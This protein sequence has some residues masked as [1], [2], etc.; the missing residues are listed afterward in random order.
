M[1][2]LSGD[3]FTTAGVY[4][5]GDT[6]VSPLLPGFSMDVSGTFENATI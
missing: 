3:E 2:I 5:E 1:N 6:L 4:G